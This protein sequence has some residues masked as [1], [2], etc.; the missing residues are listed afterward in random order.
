MSAAAAGCRPSR[1]RPRSRG[2]RSAARRATSS[3]SRRATT[4][5]PTTPHLVEQ[6]AHD[7]GGRGSALAAVDHGRPASLYW[8]VRAVGGRRGLRLERRRA[9][10]CGWSRQH[11]RVAARVDAERARATCAGRRHGCHRLPGLVRTSASTRQLASARSSRRSRPSP[12]SA[13]TTRC[14]R[15]RGRRWRVRAVRAALRKDAERPAGRLVWAVECRTRAH[16][17]PADES[18]PMSTRWR[19]SRDASPCPAPVSDNLSVRRP[20]HAGTVSRT[21]VPLHRVYV[22]TAGTA[23]TSSTAARLSAVPRTHRARRAARSGGGSG[24]RAE[25]SFL[26]DGKEGSTLSTTA[27]RSPRTRLLREARLAAGSCGAST[28]GAL[29]PA[30]T[31]PRSEAGQVDLWDRD[32]NTGPLLLH[33]RP[34]TVVVTRRGEYHETELRRTHARRDARGGW[35]SAAGKDASCVREAERRAKPLPHAIGPVDHSGLLMG[36]TGRPRSTGL[37]SSRG[38]PRRAAAYDVEWSNKPYPWRAVGQI[39][40][41]ATSAMLPVTSGTWYYRVRGINASLP[42]QPEDT[43]SDKVRIQIAKPTFSVSG[44]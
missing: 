17:Q 14:A 27:R 19:P 18:A 23:S 32:G 24:E 36:A 43:W 34:G 22:A 20:V 31:R 25:R 1:G 44:G 28:A 6:D 40:T 15:R 10:T 16:V 26:K 5:A 4:S 11:R 29:L 38:S 12:T 37:R 7:A 13:S 41:P 33:R 30:T 9:S 21:K 8:H 3:S 2:A 35:G 42:G 39:R